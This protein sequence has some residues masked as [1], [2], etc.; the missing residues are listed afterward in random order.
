MDIEVAA[1]FGD[2]FNDRV[3]VLDSRLDVG[4]RLE[5]RSGAS[6]TSNWTVGR[7]SSG[8]A[9]FGKG[10]EFSAV[11]EGFCPASADPFPKSGAPE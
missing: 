5:R 11:F 1:R 4:L 8:G 6:W 7:L 9:G 10:V 2:G 3:N